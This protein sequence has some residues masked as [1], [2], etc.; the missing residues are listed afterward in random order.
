MLSD[1]VMEFVGHNVAVTNEKAP[2]NVNAESVH[3]QRKKEQQLIVA[4]NADHITFTLV[5]A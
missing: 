3:V 1:I 5:H 2:E 4:L